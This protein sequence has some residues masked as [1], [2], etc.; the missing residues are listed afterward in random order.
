MDTDTL[1]TWAGNAT[2]ATL[3]F[4]AYYGA[5]SAL[6]V[7]MSL[8]RK[9]FK[10][11]K[12][13]D[14]FLEQVDELLS[15]GDY[16]GIAALCENDN[17]ALPQLILLAVANRNLG[18]RKVRELVQERFTRDVLSPM[19]YYMTWVLT[20]IKTGPMWGLLGTV[21]GM[22][23]AFGQLAAAETVKASALAGNISLALLTTAIGLLI[24]IPLMMYVS[25]VN[26]RIRRLEDLVNSGVA[27][28]FETLQIALKPMGRAS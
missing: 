22:M 2:Y 28:F 6:V 9:R 17:R 26:L 12:A 4:T 5:Y 11:E 15:R 27:R 19:E 8:S 23:G 25:I 13:Q 20:M 10:T 1:Y 14:E 18:A 21:L 16:N 7:W 24:A 3:A